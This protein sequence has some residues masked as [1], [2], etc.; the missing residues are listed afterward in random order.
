MEANDA[1]RITESAN[2]CML[3][4]KNLKCYN[5]IVGDTWA[6]LSSKDLAEFDANNFKYFLAN[7]LLTYQRETQNHG[8][9]TIN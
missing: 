9:P 1:I 6:Y 5:V 7:L 2:C 3:W 4:N 8:A